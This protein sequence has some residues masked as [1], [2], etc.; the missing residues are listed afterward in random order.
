[1]PRLMVLP[2]IY[3]V[4]AQS[5]RRP[6]WRV[7]KDA[8]ARVQPSIEEGYEIIPVQNKNQRL[9]EDSDHGINDSARKPEATFGRWPLL[10][11]MNNNFAPHTG[12]SS[13]LL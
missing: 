5:K 4:F 10:R 13:Q 11:L 12:Q 3:P 7:C 2:V 6:Y 1:M 9:W 8:E